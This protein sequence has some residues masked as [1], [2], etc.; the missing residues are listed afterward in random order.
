MGATS[1][2]FGAKP[3]QV[4]G[5][6]YNT[7]GF[8]TIAIASGYA[9]NIGFGDFVKLASDG[10]I[11]KDTGTTTLTPM[12]IFVGC[13]YTDP[14]T[15]QKLQRQNWPTG[16]VAADA[17]AFV[18]NDPNA[19]FLMEADEALAQTAVG[20]NAAVVQGTV[21][22]VYGISR[23]QLDASTINTTSTLPL[24]ILGFVD[25]GINQPS[26]SYPVVRCRFN[27]HQ[28]TTLTGV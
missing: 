18:V 17:V 9:A 21:D 23:N 2:P 26:D 13:E 6:G 4:A 27:N 10:T 19:E 14:N 5:A 24:R 22:S 8:R 20:N 7:G 28:L 11:Q 15:K 12:G 16:T 3:V 25:D 1:R